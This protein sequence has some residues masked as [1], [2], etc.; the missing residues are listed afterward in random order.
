VPGALRVA[1]GEGVSQ[2][3][4]GAG[5]LGAVVD[6]LAV[7][8]LP[9]DPLATGTHTPVAL[10]VTLLAGTAGIVGVT[11]VTTSLQRVS[12]ECRLTSADRPVVLTNLTVC[13]LST[14]GTNLCSGKSPAA[15]EWVSC[16]S[17]GAPAYG[18]MILDT[19]ISPLATAD[20]TG[21]DTLVILASS[22]GATVTVLVTLSLNASCVGV[23]VVAWQAGA[24]RTTS[25][26]TALS[27][28]ST[29]A[30]DTRVG[31]AA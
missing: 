1:P 10:S 20:A 26:V 7:G 4:R 11:L 17:L 22:L 28:T 16:C 27:S 13:V 31:P 19:A 5:A 15:S 29:D 21:V 18:D 14:R 8:V 25:F 24:H 2:E 30:I 9:A 6:G 12:D 23:S 3:V